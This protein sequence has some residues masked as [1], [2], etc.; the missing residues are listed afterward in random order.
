M[1]S[2][3]P[4]V[5][6]W[7]VAAIL[8]L[9]PLV[10]WPGVFFPH[11]FTKAILFYILVELACVFWI[12]L[13]ISS[14]QYR[15]RLSSLVASVLI[16]FAVLILA[17]AT[18]LNWGHSLWSDLERMTGLF[19]MLHLIV[20]FLITS[21]FARD[22]VYRNLL[23]QLSF[24]TSVLVAIIGLF[25]LDTAAV[26][27]ESTVGNAAFLATYLLVHVFVGLMLLLEEKIW[28]WRTYTYIVG[29]LLVIVTL[30]F[31][32]TRAGVLGFL[33]GI[34]AL[35]FLFLFFSDSKEKTLGIMHTL[36]K[37][38][39]WGVLIGGIL[40]LALV[41]TLRE[42]LIPYAPSALDRYLSVGIQERTVEGR[43][44]IWQ[45]VW[46]GIQE[47]PL[48]GWGTDNQH[49]LVDRHYDARLYMLEPWIDRAHN[50]VFDMGAMAGV[51]GMLAYAA[52]IILAFWVLYK[53][54]RAGVFSF[55]VAASL[56]ALLI[57]YIVQNI[58][59]FDTPLSYVVFFFILGIIAGAEEKEK[60]SYVVPQWNNVS[61]AAVIVALLVLL[62]VGHIGIW[63][64]WRANAAAFAGWTA[65]A[66]GEGDVGAIASFEKALSYNTYGNIDF[67][68]MF[69]EYIFEFLK[70]GGQRPDES[71]QR[72]MDHAV[73]GIEANMKEAPENVKWWMYQGELYNLMAVKFD[74]SFAYKAEEMYTQARTL[75]GE[76]PQIYLELAQARKT[77]GDIAGMWQALD[78][79]QSIVPDGYEALHMNAATLA[80]EVKDAQREQQEVA[81]LMQRGRGDPELRDAY[82]R[83]K[84]YSDAVTFQLR[85]IAKEERRSGPEALTQEQYFTLYAHLAAL[86]QYAGEKAKARDAALRALALNPSRRSEVEAFLKSI[87]Y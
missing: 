52:M 36:L 14:P 62:P 1:I 30:I 3:F 63:K 70:Q 5:V 50:I 86:Y 17:S 33:A 85:F 77:Q 34:V 79:L 9:V 37:R 71:L 65:L 73:V 10:Y 55:W 13:V 68:R 32:E 7:L 74:P 58:F 2:Y 64:P 19:T 25:Q 48:L 47:R 81:W 60:Y 11:T 67:R 27:L 39:V 24:G 84:R 18:G 53:K 72:L 31:T 21:S 8:V 4:R 83:V 29:V 12:P 40:A 23:L 82:F 46:E 51:T 26:R 44:L 87:G 41:F 49:I 59:T 43:F 76:R 22:S 61:I 75:S 66:K 28:N 80:I 42:R 57:A 20:F 78:T 54:F 56:V 16:F 69:A 6:R 35:G 15:P 38:L 45:V